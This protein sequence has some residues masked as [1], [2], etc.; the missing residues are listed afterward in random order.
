M[1]KVLWHITMSLDSFIA[2]R[3]YSTGWMFEC[4]GRSGEA[5]RHTE[6]RGG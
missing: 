6:A 1:S 5:L 3:D 2:P 4:G